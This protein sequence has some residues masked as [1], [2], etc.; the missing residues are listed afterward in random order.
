[1]IPESVANSPYEASEPISPGEYKTVM[2]NV[3]GTL[4]LAVMVSGAGEKA[5][6]LRLLL[7]GTAP[8]AGESRFIFPSD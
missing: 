8:G 6:K 1:M 4:A 3:V 7:V 2:D 5:S